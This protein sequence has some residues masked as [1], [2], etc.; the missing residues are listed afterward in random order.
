MAHDLTKLCTVSP[1]GCTIGAT[2]CP[3]G[4]IKSA[5]CKNPCPVQKTTVVTYTAHT[6]TTKISKTTK[7]VTATPSVKPA[8]CAKQVPYI[9]VFTF[10]DQS[11]AIMVQPDRDLLCFLDQPEVNFTFAGPPNK[12]NSP[13]PRT[14]G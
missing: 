10:Q 6:T 13:M 7:T 9:N 2:A 12:L 11:C 8:V 5:R 1:T 14:L 3:T 4:C